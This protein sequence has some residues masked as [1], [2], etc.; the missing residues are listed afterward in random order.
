MT[1]VVR[2]VFGGAPRPQIVQAPPREELETDVDRA[3]DEARRRAKAIVSR[4]QGSR[5]LIETG[6]LGAELG[7]GNLSRRRLGAG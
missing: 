3:E 6:P 1:Q 7:T 4:S 5:S 2:S